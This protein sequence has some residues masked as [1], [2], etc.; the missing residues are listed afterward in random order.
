MKTVTSEKLI[1]AV[2]LVKAAG[3]DGWLI[4]DRETADGGDPILPLILEG[5]LTWQSA[6][7][8][9]KTGRKI[10]VVGNF[11]AD[12]IKASGDWDEVIPYVQGIRE[13]LLD[14]LERELPAT[15]QAPRLAIN[16]SLEDAK[17]DGIRHGM[18][19]KL[20]EYLRGTRFENTL[21]SAEEIAM[22]LRSRKTAGEISRISHAIDET[23]KLFAKIPGRAR[24]GVS[25]QDI[26]TAVQTDIDASGYG[27]GWDRAGNPIVNTGPDSMV[28]HGKPSSHIVIK[29]GHILHLDLGIITQG[30]SSDIQRCWYIARSGE[31]EL[32]A[33]VLKAQSAVVGAITR[34]AELVRPGAVGWELDKIARDFIQQS[35]YP[36]YLHAL[37]HQV[38][39]MAHDGGGIIGPCWERY[40]N[41]PNL[42]LQENQVYTL[43]LGVMVEGR[44][45]LGLEEII[46]VTATGCRWLTRRQKSLPILNTP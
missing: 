45:Y 14:T 33:D 17:A 7:L 18:Y 27:Y 30:Y 19:L 25:E 42:P 32:P 21:V 20:C 41:T 37:G 36:E 38:G 29:P 26:Y 9:T 16:Y 44:G 46:Q 8:V 22:P 31:T 2:D 39:R 12:P 13:S 3:V 28:G 40:G 34:A 10:A 23:E 11:D 4:F 15:D 24:P 1:Q 43:E 35:G 6:L 5:G